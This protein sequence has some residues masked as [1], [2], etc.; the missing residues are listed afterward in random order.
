MDRVSEFQDSQDNIEKNCLTRVL[1][2]MIKGQRSRRQ[3]ISLQEHTQ[4]VH[5]LTPHNWPHNWTKRKLNQG[6]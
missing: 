3:V 2:Q 4:H 5:S 6:D 1:C